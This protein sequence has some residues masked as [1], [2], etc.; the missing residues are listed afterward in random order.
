MGRALIIEKSDTAAATADYRELM[1]VHG[2]YPLRHQDTLRAVAQ[3][4]EAVER[5]TPVPTRTLSRAQ[6]GS[7]FANAEEPL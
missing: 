4:R 5:L 1:A 6:G 2:E 3:A 7:R